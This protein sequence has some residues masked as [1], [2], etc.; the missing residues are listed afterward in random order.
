MENGVGILSDAISRVEN[1]VGSLSDGIL[2]MENGVGSLSDGFPLTGNGVG[3]DSALDSSLEEPV[4]TYSD[5]FSKYGLRC[6]S[7]ALSRVGASY[8][9]QGRSR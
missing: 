5:I 9:A 7:L 4:G 3:S 2:R 8:M 6:T 1:G